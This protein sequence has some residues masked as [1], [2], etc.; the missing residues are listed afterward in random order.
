M[1]VDGSNWLCIMNYINSFKNDDIITRKM[2]TEH[3]CYGNVDKYRRIFTLLGHLEWV[4]NGCYKK[5]SS[6]PVYLSSSRAS[7][8][9]TGKNRDDN[10]K[11]YQRELKLNSIIFDN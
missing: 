9:T 5:I 1:M 3:L 8:I 7:L 4:D 6:I 11:N 2:L 10:I